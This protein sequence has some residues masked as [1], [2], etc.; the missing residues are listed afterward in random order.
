[1]PKLKIDTYKS[2]KFLIITLLIISALKNVVIWNY[3]LLQ[4]GWFKFHYPVFDFLSFQPSFFPAFLCVASIISILPLIFNRSAK[5]MAISL[6]TNGFTNLWLQLS[7]YL[8]LHHDM[9]L[10]GLAFLGMAMYYGSGKSFTAKLAIQYLLAVTA[11]TYLLAGIAKLSN[12]FLSGDITSDIILRADRFFYGD[13]FTLLV[14]FAVPLSFFALV[15]ELIEPFILI[16]GSRMVKKVSIL[17]T[18]PFHFGIL[19]TGTGTV[20]N[21]TYPILFWIL[22]YLAV[23]FGSK[24][25][26]TCYTKM[27]NRVDRLNIICMQVLL[28]FNLCYIGYLGFIGMEMVFTVM[29]K[30]QWL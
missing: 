18:L 4:T 8:A 21:V 1:M 5:L 10:S 14:V 25:F 23:P 28:L 13:V 7:D 2:I 29:E 3:P 15:V 20:Y 27:E 22:V 24:D 6:F 12:D 9:Y 17:C 11:G 30:Y 19:F 26:D 16:F